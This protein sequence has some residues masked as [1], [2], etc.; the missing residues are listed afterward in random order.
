MSWNNKEEIFY[1]CF[2]CRM[3]FA[4]PSHHRLCLLHYTHL[5]VVD[6]LW[7]PH[8]HVYYEVLHLV[9]GPLHLNLPLTSSLISPDIF[10]SN[11]FSDIVLYVISS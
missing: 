8:V 4:C 9:I 11:L 6:K 2:V 3:G 7:Y 5:R 1:T 10:L